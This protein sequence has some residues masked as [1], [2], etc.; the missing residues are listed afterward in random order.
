[1][2]LRGAGVGS[3]GCIVPAVARTTTR[4]QRRPLALLL[5]G[6]VIVAGVWLAGGLAAAAGWSLAWRWFAAALVWPLVPLALLIFINPRLG[7]RRVAVALT[8]LGTGAC[9]LW[10]RAGLVEAATTH[11]M[12]MLSATAPESAAPAPGP[13]REPS[14]PSLP[15]VPDR[16]VVPGESPGGGKQVADSPSLQPAGVAPVVRDGE[17]EPRSGSRCFRDVIK[18]ARS[19]SAYGTTL[20]DL[21]GDAIL[22]AVAIV[23]GESPEIRVWKGDRGAA[24]IPPAASPTTAAGCSSRSSTAMATASSTS[25]PPIT[26]RRP[27]RC[28][29]ARA[30]AA[31][32][33]AR[34]RRPTAARSGLWPPTSTSMVSSTWSSAIT[35]MS[36]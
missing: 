26:A 12:W 4:A 33:V 3:A 9:A 7:L 15:V 32:A 20:V 16:P 35:S 23:P 1:M 25:P 34:R 19:D 13:A 24:S 17:G 18:N 11:A 10:W 29:S 28:G 5:G 36:R 14:G 22:D 31:C 2:D 21:D 30:T 6:L 8:L 27:S